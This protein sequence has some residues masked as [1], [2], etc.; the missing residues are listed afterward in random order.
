MN[1]SMDDS[2]I[3]NI[4]E[5]KAFLTSSKKM[6]LKMETTD[7]KYKFINKVIKRFKYRRLS[8]KEKH[9][10]LVYLKKVTGYK[11][12]NCLGW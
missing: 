12:P 1:I 7:E 4:S 5:L 11:K 8:R 10:V 2:R 9:I 3:V 6:V